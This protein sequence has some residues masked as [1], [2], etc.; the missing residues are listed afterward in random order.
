MTLIILWLIIQDA[1][2]GWPF[3]RHHAQPA[4]SEHAASQHLAGQETRPSRTSISVDDRQ[5]E[6]LGISFEKVRLERIDASARHAAVVAPDESRISHVH[7]RVSGWV[8]RLHVNTVGQAVRVGQPLAEI[9][10]QEL[11]ASQNEYLT[12]RRQSGTLPGSVVLDAAR[13]RLAVLGLSPA[14]IEELERT[15]SPRRLVTIRAVRNGIVLKRGVSEGTAVDPSTELMTIADLTKVWI[16]AEVPE[17]DAAPIKVGTPA[18]LKFAASVREPFV[19]RVEFIYPTLSERTRTMRVRFAVANGDATLR[20]GLYGTAAFA[21]ARREALTVP[22][23]AVVDTGSTQ[24]VFVRAPGGVL[25][26]RTVRLG[27]RLNDRLEILSGLSPGDEVAAAGVFLIDSE[28]RLR[29]SG[30]AGHFGHGPSGAG[31]ERTDEAAP[32]PDAEHAPHEH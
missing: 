26:P 22:R 32:T 28:S 15:E 19:A 8:E 17:A 20:P 23:D 10:S 4:P 1:R 12:A 27:T 24:H 18:T 13:T 25:E 2:H 31:S 9:F 14:Q 30:S 11:L 3:T 21:V 7:T 16:F 5:V 6:L 29:A